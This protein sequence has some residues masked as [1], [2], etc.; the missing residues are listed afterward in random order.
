VESARAKTSERVDRIEAKYRIDFSAVATKT[1]LKTQPARSKRRVVR[2]PPVFMRA[3]KANAKAL[4]AFEMFPY[5]HKKEYVEWIAGA[6]KPETRDRRI[7]QAIQWMAG[8]KSR[9]WK[10][11]RR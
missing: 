1:I 10:Y 2:V 3:I 4:A 9:N 7:V 11:E 6:K 5:S 8:G